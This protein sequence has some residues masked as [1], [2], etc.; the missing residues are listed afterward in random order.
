MR[1][2]ITGLFLS[3]SMTTGGDA[4]NNAKIFIEEG[5]YNSKGIEAHKASIT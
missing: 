4:W 1:A 5:N 3:I 2:I